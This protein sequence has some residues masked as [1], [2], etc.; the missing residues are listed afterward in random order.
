MTKSTAKIPEPPN[1]IKLLEY[2]CTVSVPY[3]NDDTNNILEILTNNGY[4]LKRRVKVVLKDVWD[5]SYEILKK[6]EYTDE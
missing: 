5:I 3:D 2:V 6:V 4:Y 1:N